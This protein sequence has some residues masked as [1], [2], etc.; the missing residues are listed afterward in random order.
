MD[1]K[2]IKIKHR[3]RFNFVE[4]GRTYI[5]EEDLE[6]KDGKYYIPRRSEYYKES[7][8]L[9]LDEVERRLNNRTPS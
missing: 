5:A 4:N 9:I 3:V 1:I 8:D 2:N 6:L 7:T